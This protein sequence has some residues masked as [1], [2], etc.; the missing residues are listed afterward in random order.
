MHIRVRLSALAVPMVS[1]TLFLGLHLDATSAQ[2]V[3][4]EVHPIQTM[5]LTDHQFLTGARDGKP[6]II[7]GELR[8]PRSG[9]DRLP[10]VVLVHGSGGLGAHHERWSQELN[11]IGIAT[12][13]I[14]GFTGRGLQTV[15][16][17]QAQLG[18]LA[19]VFDVYRALALLAAHPRLDPARI[20]ILGGSRGGS[21]ALRASMRR[22]QRAYAPEGL[23]FAAYLSFYGGC[24]L[25]YIGDTD[26]S[27][28]PIRLFHGTA[29]DYVPVAPCRAY[30]ER[31]RSAGR[32]VRLAEYPDAWHQFD[33]PSRSTTPTR[34]PRATTNRRCTLKEEPMGQIINADTRQ[35]FTQADPCVERGPH[36]A[37]NPAAHAAAIQAVKDLL[38][39]TFRL[40]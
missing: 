9:S 35:P 17:D 21:V 32:D 24:N 13:L 31:L 20:A 29:D 11:G 34:N 1:S 37:Y 33:N 8:L 18:R 12:F 6:T 22:F 7:A 19:M 26:V 14:D 16:E 30:V 4:I 25:T 28:K 40:N 38:R 23:E 36:L 3:R 5:T 2:V 39:A 10:A 15:S 27:D